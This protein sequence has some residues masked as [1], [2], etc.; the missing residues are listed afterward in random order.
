MKILVLS[1]YW[2]P[3]NGV[4]QRRWSWLTKLLVDAGH[5][6]LVIAP[7]PHY[8]RKVDKKRWLRQLRGSAE[9]EAGTSGERIVRSGFMPAGRALTSR[10]VNQAVVAASMVTTRLG[11]FPELRDYRPDVVIGTVPAL[12]TA[13]ITKLVA[14]RLRAPYIIDLRDA[15]PEL[16]YNSGDWNA[17]VGKRSFREKIASLGPLQALVKVTEISIWRT[18]RQAD[19][20]ITTS[21]DLQLHLQEIFDSSKTSQRFA[22]VRNVFPPKTEF[23]PVDKK[24]RVSPELNVLYAGTIG[25]AQKLDNAIA[26]AK[27]AWERG[28][29]VNLRFVGDGASWLNLQQQISELDFEVSI[30]HRL[31]ADDLYQH[32]DWADTALVHLTDWAPLARTIPSKAYELMSL[33]IHI[34]GVVEGEAARLIEELHAGHVVA[35][36]DPAALADLWEQL[37]T[38]RSLLHVTSEGRKWVEHQRNEIV[39]EA[40]L[41]I[42]EAV[43]VERPQ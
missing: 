11:R 5:E 42:V 27:I 21:Q 23:F 10:I 1:Q 17:G 12:P 13:V 29:K 26:A 15:W 8:L 43:V 24:A 2:A 33:G 41:G 39:P 18:L 16:L 4:P 3:E 31:P 38:D 32:Y 30:E 40:F 25:R 14:A 37:V 28:L 9:I 6:V 34:C 22:T 35:P 19:G 7:P 36:E 20:I